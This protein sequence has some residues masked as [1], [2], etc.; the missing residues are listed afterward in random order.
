LLKVS[1]ESVGHYEN[2]RRE[3]DASKLYKITELGVNINWL[4][5][6]KGEMML[7]EEG[8]DRLDQIND[9]LDRLV[10]YM[11]TQVSRQADES[12][13]LLRR[14]SDQMPYLERTEVIL[15][16]PEKPS[17]LTEEE[18]ER[19]NRNELALRRWERTKHAFNAPTWALERFCREVVHF[20][21]GGDLKDVGGLLK[22]FIQEGK[23]E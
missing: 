18:A 11:R 9:K 4:L 2:G 14:R 19:W 22:D 20:Y 23:K 7:K 1:Y 3:L 10:S 21:E 8:E 13:H 6:G 12:M 15:K 16:F 17:D 5:T